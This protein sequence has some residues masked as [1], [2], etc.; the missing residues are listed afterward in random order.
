MKALI[1]LFSDALQ[2]SARP[3]EPRKNGKGPTKRSARSHLW[4]PGRK[5]LRPA[6]G[7]GN[8]QGKDFESYALA[9]ARKRLQLALR[10]DPFAE[11][12]LAVAADLELSREL[13]LEAK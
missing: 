12:G 3:I 1:R 11:K 6:H 10:E 8:W 5:R 2:A 13:S 9:D 7:R 4:S